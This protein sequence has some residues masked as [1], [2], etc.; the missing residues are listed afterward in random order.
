MLE[1]EDGRVP[2][3]RPGFSYLPQFIG[4]EESEQL[5]SYFSELRPLWEQRHR[6]GQAERDAKHGRRLTRP[7]YWLGAW[8]FASLGYYAEP[9]HREDRCV[10]AE[11][12][13]VVMQRVLERLVPLLHEE[14]GDREEHAH[15]HLPNTCLV[16]FYGREVGK[17][18]PRDYARL[19][20]H[21]DGEPG[22]VVMF[23]I[24]QPGRLEFLDPSLSPEPEL[25][26]W[27]RHRSVTILSGADYKD[28]LYHRVTQ[29]RT[30]Q[31]PVMHSTV[32]DFELRRISVSFRHVPEEVIS[33]F[34][35][36]PGPARDRVR[37]YVQQLAE[38]SPHFRAQ[39]ESEAEPE[40]PE[41]EPREVSGS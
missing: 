10:R 36:L 16:N 31:H 3:R 17:G 21:R 28:R 32:P 20:M 15:G 22:P 34:G 33:D 19:R 23:N 35:Q 30:G 11:G 40:P 9:E 6:D 7:V 14:H 41:P 12:F 18:V 13:P 38:H 25:A 29:V 37:E 1:P 5:I 27:T 26:L 2:I 4:K 24:G 8:Q 39:L